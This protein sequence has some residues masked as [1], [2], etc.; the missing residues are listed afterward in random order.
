MILLTVMS[1]TV[2]VTPTQ[3]LVCL[4]RQSEVPFSKTS[5]TDYLFVCLLLCHLRHVRFPLSILV[6]NVLKYMCVCVYKNMTCEG[7]KETIS[8]QITASLISDVVYD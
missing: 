4:T 6:I 2:V 7:V 8:S 3:A 1:P 5:G